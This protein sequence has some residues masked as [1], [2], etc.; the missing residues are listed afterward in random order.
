[1]FWRKSLWNPFPRSVIP[2]HPVCNTVVASCYF[3]S[4]TLFGVEGTSFWSCFPCKSYGLRV[5]QEY[6]F[7]RMSKD[8]FV[9]LY[10]PPTILIFPSKVVPSLGLRSESHSSA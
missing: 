6:P 2:H 4:P 7:G 5:V 3:R 10:I 1:M 8:R 9:L